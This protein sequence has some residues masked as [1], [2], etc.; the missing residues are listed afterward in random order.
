MMLGSVSY[1]CLS[2]EHAPSRIGLQDPVQ[3]CGA[4]TH[5]PAE[6]AAMIPPARPPKCLSRAGTCDR[7]ELLPSTVASFI[8][9]FIGRAVERVTVK[10]AAPAFRHYDGSF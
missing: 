6:L 8:S 1:S 9:E 3:E 5:N 2:D 4:D 10:K 7:G